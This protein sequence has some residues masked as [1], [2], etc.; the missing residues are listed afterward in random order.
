MTRTLARPTTIALA[1]LSIPLLV[2]SDGGTAWAGPKG[3]TVEAKMSKFRND[4]GNALVALFK[5]GQ[6]FPGEYRKSSKWG[7]ATI[8][9][10]KAS[11]KFKDVP[12]GVYAIAVL[13]D[14]NKNGKMETNFLGIPKEG[15]GASRNPR[16]TVGAPDFDD[17][18]FTVKK[19][20]RAFK[21]L[22]T[23]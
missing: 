12:P 20:D 5:K 8:K 2:G 22:M 7:K 19:G 4:K 16:P 1:L 3:A 10:K 6:G 14:E 9:G 11:Y 18:K 17:A 13:H 21:V 15:W 23:Y